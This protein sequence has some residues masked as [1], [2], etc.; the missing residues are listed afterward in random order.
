MYNS[1]FEQIDKAAFLKQYWQ[2]GACFFKGAFSVTKEFIDADSLA[3]LSIED[4]IESRIVKRDVTTNQWSTL[5][6]PFDEHSFNDLPDSDWTLLVQSVD[7]WYPQAQELLNSFRFIPRWRFDDLMVSYATDNGGVGPHSDNYD[8]FLLQTSGKRRWRVGA[9]GDLP[10]ETELVPGMRHL[11]EFE[12]FIDVVMEP[13][14]MLYIPPNTAH[15]GVSLGESI[16]YSIGYRS[17]QTKNLLSLLLNEFEEHPSTSTYFA[18]N[19]R[20]DENYSNHLEDNLVEWAQLQLARL[21]ADSKQLKRL[22]SQNL[23]LSKLGVYNDPPLN[24]PRLTRE[25]IVELVP[26]V[27]VNWYETEQSVVLNIEGYRLVLDKNCKKGV[28]RL[29]SYLPTE[30][31]LFNN[32]PELVDFSPE[33]SNLVDMGHIKQLN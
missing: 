15:W 16:G 5:H 31:K 3:G 29:A 22:L 7:S 21:S 8:V 17:L 1:P 14:D 27:G 2:T 13:G 19:Y 4:E 12:P 23:S 6:G 20:S 30:I 28:I 10:K 33:L 9:T 32:S 24:K 25:S 11:T 26:E 18:D